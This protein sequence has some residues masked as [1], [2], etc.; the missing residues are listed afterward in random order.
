MIVYS[1]GA[2]AEN[3]ST[4]R[5]NL[6]RVISDGKFR[7][8]ETQNQRHIPEKDSD[9]YH[10]VTNEERDRLDIISNKFYQTPTFWWAIALANDLIDP[11][12]IEPGTTL[13]IP[14]RDQLYNAT[15]R[16]LDR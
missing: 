3:S 14:S 8:L 5:Y 15:N 1:T 13:R 7:Y 12:N 9:I 2:N 16:I 4:S 10:V 6:L 11:F